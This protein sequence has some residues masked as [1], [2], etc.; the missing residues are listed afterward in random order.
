MIG[1]TPSADLFLLALRRTGY[2]SLL[3][4]TSKFY[5]LLIPSDS[6]L[7]STGYTK[8]VITYLDPTILAKG[9]IYRSIL[10]GDYSDSLLDGA[11]GYTDVYT[12]P[13]AATL[14]TDTFY[15]AKQAGPTG[16]LWMSGVRVSR[17]RSGVPASNGYIHVVDTFYTKPTINAWTVLNSKP[18]F[19]Y[20]VAACR[21]N[22]SIVNSYTS[23]NGYRSNLFNVNLPDTE[24]FIARNYNISNQTFFVPT[25]QAF[26]NAGFN[27]IDD[28]R[29]YAVNNTDYSR[30][31]YID[32]LDSLIYGLWMP[33][34]N[35]SAPPNGV[36]F[37]YFDL[38]KNPNINQRPPAALS[39][40][41]PIET[42]LFNA[43]T[44]YNTGSYGKISNYPGVLNFHVQDTTVSVTCSSNS[45]LPPAV[46]VE[47]D[48]LCLNHILIHGVDHLLWPY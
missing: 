43:T 31:T 48:M 21:I 34:I 29:N 19:S 27:T 42:E 30:P 39:Y 5:T 18:E 16:G 44:L 22:D 37:F 33:G 25:N 9:I 46:I 36:N 23:Y 14:L 3:R 2:D 28:I 35:Y 10:Y 1:S 38:L 17:E 7:I 47:R 41:K 26:I 8:D 45:N 13:D 11:T 12:I 20:F 4:Q 15:I 6:L 24:V 32:P 40:D